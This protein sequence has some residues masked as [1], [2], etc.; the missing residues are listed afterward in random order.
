VALKAEKDKEFR[1]VRNLAN[2]IFAVLVLTAVSIS[3]LSYMFMARESRT[4]DMTDAIQAGDGREL[5][6]RTSIL[7][8]QNSLLRNRMQ[9]IELELLK[10]KTTPMLEQKSSDEVPT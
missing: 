1:L 8:Y 7:L 6:Y 2:S 10:V 3:F 9:A 5:R 4:R